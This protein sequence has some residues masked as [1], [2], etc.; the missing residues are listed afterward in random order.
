MSVVAKLMTIF[1]VREDNGC[2]SV[3]RGREESLGYFPLKL[4]ALQCALDHARRHPVC[5]LSVELAD[6]RVEG[7]LRFGPNDPAHRDRVNAA[8]PPGSRC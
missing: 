1:H 8:A 4:E 2:W 3:M 7:E 5:L 6:G